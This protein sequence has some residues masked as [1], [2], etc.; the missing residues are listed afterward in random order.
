MS[1]PEHTTHFWHFEFE[2]E[3]LQ[4]YH[5]LRPGHKR[6][7]LDC[8]RQI[9][10]TENPYAG[11]PA[12]LEILK[13]DYYKGVL[14]YRVGDYRVL[15]VIDSTP[16]TVQSHDYKGTVRIIDIDHRKDIYRP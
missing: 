5:S 10:R 8:L 16:V 13:G 3:A 9:L 4:T 2:E 15:I 12:C 7:V 14:K 1:D 11:H 6:S